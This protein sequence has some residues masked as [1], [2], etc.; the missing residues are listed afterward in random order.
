MRNRVHSALRRHWSKVQLAKVA[1]AA[2]LGKE[3]NAVFYTTLPRSLPLYQTYLRRIG[4]I[5]VPESARGRHSGQGA[6]WAARRA[7]E[8][9]NMSQPAGSSGSAAPPTQVAG[10]VGSAMGRA[11]S[12]RK[13]LRGST[14]AAVFTHA[15]NRSQAA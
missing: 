9:K 10:P 5:C 1:S 3:G 2:F 11:S 13:R 7:Q 4:G 8:L 6:T 15:E 12:S 14:P